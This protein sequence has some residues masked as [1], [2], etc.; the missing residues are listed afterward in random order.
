MSFDAEFVVEKKD[1]PPLLK[2]LEK[3]L[4]IDSFKDEKGNLIL[5]DRLR[6]ISITFYTSIGKEQVDV[7][8]ICPKHCLE[9]L[10][11]TLGIPKSVK[12]RKT[13]V[14]TFVKTLVELYEKEKL[15]P[16]QAVSHAINFF[17][18]DERT[19]KTYAGGIKAIGSSSSAPHELKV[20]YKILKSAKVL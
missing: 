9:A 14:K 4:K 11:K 8:S 20:A 6:G 2:A 3:R 1:I 5:Q 15:S 12:K 10:E 17:E 7:V 19:L 13:R 18:I 16:K